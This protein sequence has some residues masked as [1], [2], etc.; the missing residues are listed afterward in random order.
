VDTEAYSSSNVAIQLLAAGKLDI[1]EGSV[2]GVLPAIANGVPIKAFCPYVSMAPNVMVGIGDVTS[3]DDLKDPKTRVAIE[4]PGGP[5]VFA[6]DLV[7]L[8]KNAGFTTAD[9]PNQKILESHSLRYAALAAGDADTAIVDQQELRD[10][11]DQLGADQVHIISN[12]A[13]DASD[14]IYVAFMAKTDWLNSHHD[15]AVAFC[16]AVMDAMVRLEDDYDGF[17]S[18]TQQ[19]LESDISDDVFKAQWDAVRAGHLWPYDRGITEESY[20]KVD[21]ISQ[22]EGLTDASVPYADVIDSSIYEE[23]KEQMTSE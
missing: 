10:L 20:A 15:Q 6:T 9:I 16:A 21:Q 13:E 22:S 17:V 7:L 14:G 19:L 12:L 23:A 4:S 8:N 11:Q 3:V 2:L 18:T 5:T 1:I